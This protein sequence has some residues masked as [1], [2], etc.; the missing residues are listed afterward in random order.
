MA[1]SLPPLNA[2]RTFE[3]AASRLNFTQAAEVLH[4]TQSAVSQQIRQ[5]EGQLGVKLFRRLTRRLELTEEGQLLYEGAHA[6]LSTLR[7]TMARLERQRFASRL[8]ISVL[9]SFASKWLVPRLHRFLKR[10]SGVRVTVLPSVELVEFATEDVDVALR[11]CAGEWPG[12]RS[13]RIIDETL[14]PVCAPEFLASRGPI[15]RPA[16]LLSCPLL[17]DVTHDVWRDWFEFVGCDV[18][19][20][21]IG[22]YYDDAS[23]LIQ[24]AIDGQGVALARSVLVVDDLASRRLLRV[25]PGKMPGERAYYLLV[26]PRHVHNPQVREFARWLEEE[27]EASQRKL[28]DA[29]A[30]AAPSGQERLEAEA[31][32]R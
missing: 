31:Q 7:D 12:L 22:A 15:M 2:L 6:A 27:A 28:V 3:A 20:L 13:Q 5:L 30:T 32:P 19:E 25:I 4:L 26:P 1:R 17:A 8:V 21:P 11:W 10:C 24:A 9:P 29:F 18:N 14:F 23:N 16:D